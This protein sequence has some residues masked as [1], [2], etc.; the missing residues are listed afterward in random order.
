MFLDRK[1]N[2][3]IDTVKEGGIAEK[4]KKETSIL[5]EQFSGGRQ[6]SQANKKVTFD[7]L[8]YFNSAKPTAH[9]LL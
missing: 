5:T 9:L 6:C 3:R 7:Q 2:C 1:E 8:T 4:G